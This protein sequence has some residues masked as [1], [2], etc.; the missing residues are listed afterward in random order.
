MTRALRSW[1]GVQHVMA[2]RSPQQT[3]LIQE[4]LWMI[5]RKRREKGREGKGRFNTGRLQISSP[6]R[7]S[8]TEQEQ[9]AEGGDDQ[10]GGQ[11]RQGHTPS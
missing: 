4:M 6:K 9:H 3:R 10:R 5:K 8:P 1:K 7:G 2:A 11:G